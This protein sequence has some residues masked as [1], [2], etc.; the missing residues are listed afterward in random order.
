MNEKKWIGNVCCVFSF[1]LIL[2]FFHQPHVFEKTFFLNIHFIIF[3]F[4]SV[5]SWQSIATVE[6]KKSSE[7]K[8][9]EIL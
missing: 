2:N 1:L 3:Q 8:A 7:K 6:K 4:H 9:K 5:G